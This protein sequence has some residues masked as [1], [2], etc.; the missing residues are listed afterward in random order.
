MIGLAAHERTGG[1]SNANLGARRS[2]HSGRA[3]GG[4][5]APTS[6]L[7]RC[8]PRHRLAGMLPPP[9][10]SSAASAFFPPGASC[11]SVRSGAPPAARSTAASAAVRTCCCT[12]STL[13]AAST[14]CQLASRSALNCSNTLRW[15]VGGWVWRG[16]G[17]GGPRGT[18]P[19]SLNTPQHAHP[20]LPRAASPPPPLNTT[21][22][23]RSPRQPHPTHPRARHHMCL[24]R[25]APHICMSSRSYRSS[26]THPHARHTPAPRATHKHPHL[27]VLPL[28]PLFS[29]PPPRCRR[30]CAELQE[31]HCIWGGQPRVGGLAPLQ[32]QPGHALGR[33]EGHP[34]VR[35]AIGHHGHPPPQLAQQLLPV[36]RGGIVGGG[37]GGAGWRWVRGG[38]SPGGRCEGA[39]SG[40]APARPRTRTHR[41]SHRLAEKSRCTAASSRSAWLVR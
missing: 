33:R 41:F 7:R 24:S 34:A 20:L 16:P 12:T 4:G 17:E 2:R 28:V 15:G 8:R 40:D 13:C 25:P 18:R 10:S 27:H 39:A 26:P 19:H 38:A 29:I 6:E 9:P 1:N 37:G 5:W 11:H 23:H 31:Q 22:S 30:L 14:T 36:C 32:V 35:V 21:Q 3:V